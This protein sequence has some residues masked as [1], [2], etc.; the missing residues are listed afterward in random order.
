MCFIHF[1]LTC[2]LGKLFMLENQ[3]NS[4]FWLTTEW[5]ES[6]CAELLYFAEHQA[7]A[8]GGKRPTWTRLAAN[9]PHV[10]TID[11]VCPGD[12]QH[13]LWGIIRQ[14]ASKRVFATALEVHYPPELCQAIVHAFILRLADMGLQFEEVPKLQHVARA[15][16]AEQNKSMKLPP[17]V[18]PFSAKLVAFFCN[19][20]QVWPEEP[21]PLNACK[22]LHEF[23]EGD[24]VVVK[25]LCTG[26]LKNR[27]ETA[28]KIWGIDL[29]LDGLVGVDA[30]VDMV[31]FFGVQREPCDFLERACGVQ[32]PLNPVLALPEVLEE[33]VRFTTVQGFAAVAKCRV[34]FFEC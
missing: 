26:Q 32:H 21:I 18:P 28:L 13:E 25:Q 22:L 3:R 30:T 23:S 2:K 12:H 31:I 9:F 24:G 15:A 20:N 1:V 34:E 6:P 19:S 33:A 8:Y 17:L 5:R 27:V 10:H 4:L 11:K 7:C 16:T 29:C 14:G